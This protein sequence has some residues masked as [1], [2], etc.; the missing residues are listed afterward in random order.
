MEK[1]KIINFVKGAYPGINNLSERTWNDVAQSLES[2]I[3]RDAEM[4]ESIARIFKTISGQIRHDVAEGL[5]MA[6]EKTENNTQ[7]E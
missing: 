3:F 2:I 1:E 4:K 7:T 6:K 5:R